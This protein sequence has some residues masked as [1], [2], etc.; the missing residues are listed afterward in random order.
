MKLNKLF[1]ISTLATSTFSNLSAD[2]IT[3]LYRDS[4]TGAVYDKDGKGR[5]ELTDIK[6][7]REVEKELDD[8]NSKL[9]ELNT[10]YK[11]STVEVKSKA[12]KLDFSGTHYLGFTSTDYRGDET[13]ERKDK[14]ETRRNY[15]QAKAHFK[16]APE[17]YLRITFDTYEI[18]DLKKFDVNTYKLDNNGTKLT[19]TKTSYSN[20]DSYGRWNLMLKYAY[21]YLDNI[22]PNTG[23]EIG[24]VHRP[25]IDYEEHHAW[26]Y[27]SIHKV[28][29]EADE[30]A[31][32]TNSA[33]L[34]V[35]FKTTIPEFSSEIGLFNGE[36]YHSPENGRGLSLEWRLTYHPL[37]TGKKKVSPKEDTYADISFFGQ[38]NSDLSKSYAKDA[39]KVTTSSNV[40]HDFNWYGFHAVYNMPSF[41]ISAQYISADNEDYKYQGKGFS[42]NGEARFGDKKEYSLIARYDKWVSDELYNSKTKEG[43]LTSLDKEGDKNNLLIGATYNLNKNVKFIGNMIKVDYKT[44]GKET[45]DH[46]KYMLTAEVKW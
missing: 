43:I 15:F 8:L 27:R 9:A 33:D 37:G 12:V 5:D 2:E 24:Q 17:S 13:K 45:L 46:S 29:V 25:W 3:T 4:K 32:L 34:G 35:N 7:A 23:V 26:W 42:A 1:L 31:H 38:Q 30:S 6:N 11:F 41:L 21:L 19:S 18:D 10:K 39:N 36:G 40:D 16:E 44:E 22:I 14:F 28:Y 20:E